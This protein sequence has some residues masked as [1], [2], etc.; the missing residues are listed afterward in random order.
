MNIAVIP[1]RGGSKRVIK[2]N[3]KEFCGK[4]MIDYAISVAK[5]L[6]LFSKVIVSTDDIEVAEIVRDLGAE[7]PFLRSDDLSDDHTPTVPVIADSIRKLGE[8][9]WEFNE[10]CCIYPCVPFLLAEDLI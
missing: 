7:V 3:I 9:G 8:L 4:P 2:K 5:E 6:A 10:V 1:A